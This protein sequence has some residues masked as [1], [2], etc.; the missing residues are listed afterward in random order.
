MNK[1]R[2]Q[3]SNNVPTILV[4]FG[5][6]GDLATKKIIPSLWRL[7]NQN[8]L[9]SSFSVIGF[10]RRNISESELKKFIQTAVRDHGGEGMKEDDF[11]RFFTL[12][13][14]QD[15]TFEN[16]EAF[17]RL[18]QSIFETE[19]L[20]KIC[21]NKLFYLAAPPSSYELIF[22]NIAEVK[23]NLPCG[24][25]LGWS[26]VLIEKPFGTDLKSSRK[27]QSL[28][29][30]YF[31]EEQI[32]RIDHYL[33]KEIVQGIENFRF[34]N[35]LFEN[36]W[37]N[38][39]IERVDI[40]LHESIGTE[41]RGSFYDSLGA[42]RDVGQN[43]LLAMLAALLMEHP[44][45]AKVGA[46]RESRARVLNM[47]APWTENIVRENTFRAQYN[48]YGNIDG[49][50]KDSTTETY[51]ALKTE[52][53][54]SRWKNV[55]ICL[56]AGKRMAEARKEIVVTLR[57]PQGCLLCEIGPHASNSIVFRLEPRDEIIIHFW[58]KKPGFDRAL[59]ERVFSFLLYDKEIRTQY[60]EEYAKVLYFAMGGEQTL[61]VSLPEI[62]AAWKFIDPI[63]SAWQRNI[64]PLAKYEP[65][66]NPIFSFSRSAPDTHEI[67]I[68]G[69]GKM[70]ANLA[71][72][73]IERGWQVYGYNKTPEE[74]KSL[75]KE[76]LFGAYSFK[77]MVKKLSSP[78][79]VWLM[80]PAGKAVDE[81]LFGKEGLA[82]ILKPG[83]I[84]IDGGN[85]FY[86]D[87]VNRFRKLKKEG[88]HF[89]DIGVSGGPEGA[90]KG[91]S[92]M[93]G[94]E[95]KIFEQLEILFRDLAKEDGYQFFEGAGA[96]HFVKM[97]HNGIEYG[98]MQ[99]IAEGFT[100]L[101][102]S[103]Y[104]LNLTRVADVY[105]RGSVIESRLIGW[106]KNALEAHGENLNNITGSVGH[107]GEGAW[108]L[109]TAKEMKLKAKVIEEALKFRI[110]SAKNP[111]YAGKILSVLREQFGG[112]QVKNKP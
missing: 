67:G 42:L 86:K 8:L 25:N 106:L 41:S 102:N 39:T 104:K 10:S 43:H 3:S 71:R 85:S 77:E 83:D 70:G 94:G 52:M 23:L 73:L 27:L 11:S 22:K 26:R 40:R 92:L 18:A 64:V 54:N 51:F 93:I 82:S 28:L 36:T 48:G 66:T 57:H 50:R 35:N 58:T 88:V 101:K 20:W 96:G 103:K 31:K 16:V 105:N 108:T 112:H 38:T 24:G 59:E 68:I 90:R 4:V 2:P 6:T 55:P 1:T 34:S 32:Y 15:G 45:G 46:S 5:I 81:V 111:N 56:E 95:K 17:H 14:Y 65:G 98:M 80:V 9:P 99:A 87:S 84:V 44:Y 60:V 74:T 49:V 29:S 53:E 97:I 69:L 72:R 91:A 47:L 12:F 63:V 78:R 30:L 61:F 75:E 37:D 21:A 13:S 79:I 107:T 33:F 89:V 100:I 7:F 62:E 110:A 76:G 109:K 19:T